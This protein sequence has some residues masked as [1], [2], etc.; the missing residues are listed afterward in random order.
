MYR[1]GVAFEQA[2]QRG[3]SANCLG[4]LPVRGGRGGKGLPIVGNA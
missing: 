2:G 1:R 4:T 3:E